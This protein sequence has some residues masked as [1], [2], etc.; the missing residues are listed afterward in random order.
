MFIRFFKANYFIQFAA[1]VLLAGVLWIDVI[2]D[3][4]ALVIGGSS[5]DF[6]GLTGFLQNYPVVI[7]VIS[8]LLL[9]F[10]AI[11]LNQILENH[12][13]M[14]RNQLLTAAIYILIVS[15]SPVL[16]SP[17]AWLFT[18]FILILMLNIALNIYGKKE[19]YR[20][21][22]DAA[23]L[24]GIASLIHFPVVIFIVFLWACL[25]TYQIFTWREWLIS[26]IGISI[27]FLFAGSYHYLTGQLDKVLNIT[28]NFFTKIQ[29]P[30]LAESIYL[31]FAW[32]FLAI[33]VFISLG[34]ISKGLTENT[35]SLRKK[36]RAVLLFFIVSLGSAVF[37]GSSLMLHL[38]ITA[39]PTSVF[40]ALYFSKTKKHFIPEVIILLLFVTILL[41]KYFNLG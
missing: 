16:T 17:L 37:S 2:V 9:L 33:L 18:N 11:L 28:A 24:I 15:S 25:V 32:G 23:F 19:P 4:S 27:P 20:D 6:F 39:I 14:E 8:M 22:F 34:Q 36:F 10:Q 38:V 41:G 26:V 31:Y 1:L 3:P 30:V 35:V 13:L 29:V 12:R 40:I 7:L 5:T 21:V